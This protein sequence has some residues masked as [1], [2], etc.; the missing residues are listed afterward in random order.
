MRPPFERLIAIKYDDFSLFPG[1]GEEE[2]L[3]MADD[4]GMLYRWKSGDYHPVGGAPAPGGGHDIQ[5]ETGATYSPRLN[6]KFLNTEV[7]DDAG[8]NATTVD[9]TAFDRPYRPTI[10]SPND[11]AVDVPIITRI[12]ASVYTHP[13]VIAVAGSRWQI[14]EY[15]DFSLI[16]MDTTQMNADPSVIVTEDAGG[17]PWL[18][19]STGYYVRMKYIDI[20]GKESNWSD[21]VGFTTSSSTVTDVILQ[22]E[23]IMPAD[24]GST[25]EHRFMSLL[26]QPVVLGVP[27]VD[28][29]DYQ[30]STTPNFAPMDILKDYVDYA[31]PTL[32]M[33]ESVDFSTAPSPLYLRAKQKDS[34]HVL[35]SVWSRPFTVWLQRAFR[36]LIIG[37]EIIV[38]K[39]GNTVWWIDK[40]GNHVNVSIDYFR[41]HPI[42]GGMVPL[43][44]TDGAGAPHDVVNLP[45]YHV[46]SESETDGVAG[47]TRIHRTW[48][49]PIAFTDRA[50]YIHPAF[51]VS[52]GGLRLFKD[53]E[54]SYG[55]PDYMMATFLTMNASGPREVRC[56][57][58]H[59][60]N[61]LNLLASIEY[62]TINMSIIPLTYR[63]V[64]Y[65]NISTQGAQMRPGR[66]VEGAYFQM[67]TSGAP[68][69]YCN[70]KIGAPASPTDMI[71]LGTIGGAMDG[72]DMAT[73]DI[74]TGYH[75]AL[76]A[77]LE[78]YFLPQVIGQAAQLPRY[79]QSIQATSNFTSANFCG[80]DGYRSTNSP[81]FGCHYLAI[82]AT[83]GRGIVVS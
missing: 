67:W 28:T 68:T 4:T 10:L 5:D 62:C 53:Q 29:M 52:P 7:I 15:A 42:W 56:E 65:L 13:Y 22:P 78:M 35:E 61:A 8:N 50:G 48:V 74:M 34:V 21:V 60:R 57:N 37:R 44:Y 38:S 49:S 19:I 63:G 64:N 58:I 81:N 55:T 33:D 75:A 40:A 32:V 43:T 72:V 70:V 31:D 59:S 66:A 36:D 54:T 2:Q 26:S 25:P 16:I 11:G 79:H 9:M 23:I 51:T 12:S 14:S 47:G 77:H 39:N 46:F 20:R 80:L 17:Q 73:M 82:G 6:L 69:E 1:T 30:I 83:W 3:Y 45:E 18:S 41:D 71:D 24:Q 76:G 27:V